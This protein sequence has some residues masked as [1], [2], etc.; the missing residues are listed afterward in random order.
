MDGLGTSRLPD[1]NTRGSWKTS[2]LAR[3]PNAKVD[4]ARYRPFSLADG[5][6]TSA[7]TGAA[8]AAAATRPMTLP[9]PTVAIAHAPRPANTSGL[10]DT[11][12]L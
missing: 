1:P 11:K 8:I 2:A 10:N 6:A 4:S 3:I 12:P 7:P 5:N 9:P